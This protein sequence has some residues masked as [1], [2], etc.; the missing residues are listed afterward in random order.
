LT[1]SPVSGTENWPTARNR[2]NV[3]EK[4]GFCAKLN[5]PLAQEKPLTVG[6]AELTCLEFGSPNAALFITENREFGRESAVVEER[7]RPVSL[8]RRTGTTS[9]GGARARRGPSVREGRLFRW[10]KLDGPK[11]RHSLNPC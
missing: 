10:P 7:A 6:D 5:R 9:R 2:A 3:L 8:P 11:A 4:L 1:G